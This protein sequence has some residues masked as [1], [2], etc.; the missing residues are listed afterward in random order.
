MPRVFFAFR[1]LLL[2]SVAQFLPAEEF[3]AQLVDGLSRPLPDVSVRV[4]CFE[5]RRYSQSPRERLLLDIQ[6]DWKGTARGKYDGKATGCGEYLIV[7]VSK[8][9]YAGYS[10]GLSPRYVLERNLHSAELNHVVELEGNAQLLALREFLAGDLLT[11]SA[12]FRDLVFYYE[13]PLRPLLRRLARDPEVAE[14][15]IEFISLIGVPE[16]L[17]FAMSLTPI[18]KHPGFENRW[19]YW[20]S[21]AL[22]NPDTEEEWSFLRKCVLNEYNDGWIV[23]GAIQSLKLSASRRS[24]EILAEA[25]KRDQNRAIS[26]KRAL[27]YINS[28]PKPLA[29]PSLKGLANRVAQAIKVGTWRGSGPARYNRAGDKALVDYY[30]HSGLSGLTYTATFHHTDGVWRFRGARETLEGF[31]P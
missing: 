24:R 6:S 19:R 9:G 15:A 10:A 28:N 21:T 27:Q 2:L 5:D 26:I 12:R 22:P 20:V 4:T 16:D 23:G 1:A 8:E 14:R 11:E 13:K 18:S 29:G 31:A 7:K 25:Q 3:S 30:F 17:S